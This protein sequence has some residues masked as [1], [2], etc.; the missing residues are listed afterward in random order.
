M[1][2]SNRL[3][4]LLEIVLCSALKRRSVKI[5]RVTKINIALL[6]IT[7]NSALPKES[8]DGNCEF[9]SVVISSVGTQK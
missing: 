1:G 8:F 3:E 5:N 6:S 9:F 2:S 7:I 4:A